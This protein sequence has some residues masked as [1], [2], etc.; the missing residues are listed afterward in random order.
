VTVGQVPHARGRPNHRTRRLRGLAGPQADRRRP[1]NPGRQHY[2]TVYGARLPHQRRPDSIA[3]SSSHDYPHSANNRQRLIEGNDP[4][5]ACSGM[6]AQARP[7]AAGG[8]RLNPQASPAAA[9]SPAHRAKG[10]WAWGHLGDKAPRCPRRSGNPNLRR[11]IPFPASYLNLASRALHRRDCQRAGWKEASYEGVTAGSPSC[12]PR[13]CRHTR[14]ALRSDG[15]V[16]CSLADQVF[17]APGHA[18]S[19]QAARVVQGRP[20]WCARRAVSWT[21]EASR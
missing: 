1:A 3:D 16:V 19:H 8:G 11:P 9:R 13:P 2:V 17:S 15:A 18:F 14:Q 10:L 5:G 20:L 6:P 21:P 7:V 4:A 12:C